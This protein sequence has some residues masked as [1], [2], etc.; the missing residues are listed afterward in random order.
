MIGFARATLIACSDTTDACRAYPIAWGPDKPM[1]VEYWCTN[2]N[3]GSSGGKG[4]GTLED[5]EGDICRFCKRGV[6]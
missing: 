2:N 5:L 1:K 3:N 6:L 4:G